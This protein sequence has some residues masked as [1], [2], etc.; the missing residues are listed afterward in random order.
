[1]KAQPQLS[2]KSTVPN[3]VQKPTN[4]YPF[5]QSYPKH[6]FRMRVISLLVLAGLAISIPAQFS[7]EARDL[8][9]SH[10]AADKIWRRGDEPGSVRITGA[11]PDGTRVTK[12][13]VRQ[14]P[15]E[16]KLRVRKETVIR[17]D[18]PDGTRVTK[19]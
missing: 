15:W 2:K 10:S 5:Y 18:D 11:E 7:I 14:D 1:M 13:Q 6:P 17:G 8:T 16:T 4:I 19:R 12:R 9:I 3:H